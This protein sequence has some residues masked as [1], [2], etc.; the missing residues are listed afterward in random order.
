LEGT[1]RDCGVQLRA[2]HRTTPKSDPMS[3]SIV[4]TLLELWHSGLCLLPWAAC[5]SVETPREK[6]LRLL[7]IITYKKVVY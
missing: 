4:Q 1:H 2:P 6:M 3:E 5:S 7:K